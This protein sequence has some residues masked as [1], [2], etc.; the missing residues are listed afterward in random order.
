MAALQIAKNSLTAKSI[1]ATFLDD[2]V[3]KDFI[4]PDVLAAIKDDEDLKHYFAVKVKKRGPKKNSGT[5]KKVSSDSERNASDFDDHR[6]CARVW[7]A[8]GGL[9]YDNIQCNSKNMVSKEDA[10]QTIKGF[11]M[12]KEKEATLE[13]Y[14]RSY[15]GCFCK[16]HLSMDFFM[17]NG[18]WLGKVN[19]PRPENPMLP[20]GSVKKGFENEFKAH[21]WMFDSEGGKV[22]KPKKKSSGRK[23]SAK[24]SKPSQEP[25]AFKEM[26]VK[27]LKKKAKELGIDQE[28][29]EDA[30]DADNVRE[31]V[32]NLILKKEEEIREKEL[33]EK[34]AAE[35]S[36]AEDHSEL[37]SELKEM[38]PKALKKKARELK[39]NED[40]IDDADDAE[41]LKEALIALI[42]GAVQSQDIT[43]KED[44]EEI[45]SEGDDCDSGDEDVTD[46]PY[47]VD[48]VTYEKHWDQEDKK[49]VIIETDEWTPVGEPDG[50]GGIVFYDEKEKEHEERVKEL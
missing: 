28:A 32:I 37:L 44:T 22:E 10:I 38:K 46:T 1:N 33:A 42:Q 9:G 26:K 25:E 47:I 39:I 2:L 27:D 31:A 18:Y 11:K 3:K 43:L 24:K 15:N 20:K 30:D 19:E 49:M 7:K 41:D 16:K 40:L 5:A 50:D 12:D 45:H 8:E 13:E 36:K 17:P 48:G 23:P 35:E 4:N 21:T 6:C 34:V 29:I 14:V